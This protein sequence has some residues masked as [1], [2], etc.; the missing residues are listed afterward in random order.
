MKENSIFH[1]TF[2]FWVVMDPFGN[3]PIFV[4]MLKHFDPAKQK[5][6]IIRELTIALGVMILFLFGGRAFFQLLK[7]SLPSLEMAGGIIL[8]IIAVN[9]IFSSPLKAGVG[10]I[11]K[12]P[13]IVPLAIPAV[14]GP[15]I[16]AT[17]TLYGGAIG[18]SKLAVLIAIVI[19]WLFLF[20]TLLFSPYL[21]KILGDNGIVAAER[22]FGYIVVLISCQMAVNGL[23]SALK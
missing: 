3:I 11:P 5:K 7:I 14:A 6:I 13:L 4:T 2:L 10:R 12:D 9:M 23:L 21:K 19:A 8:F 1:M 15:A 18:S 20:P 17:I 16:L 22:L